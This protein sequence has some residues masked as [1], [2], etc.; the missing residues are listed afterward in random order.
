M[1]LGLYFSMNGS[2][3][4]FSCNELGLGLCWIFV[5]PHFSPSSMSRSPSQ[6]TWYSRMA[7][8][9]MSQQ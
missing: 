3:A 8:M 4:E 2:L 7:S 9:E 5:R 1:P 6:S